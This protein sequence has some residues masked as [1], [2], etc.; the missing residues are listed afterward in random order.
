M[1]T[2]ITSIS[3]FVLFNCFSQNQIIK[4]LDNKTFLD[5]SISQKTYSISNLLIDLKETPEYDVALNNGIKFKVFFDSQDRATKIYTDKCKSDAITLK[6]TNIRVKSRFSLGLENSKYIYNYA[7][8]NVVGFKEDYIKNIEDSKE[9]F[10]IV[11]S[12]KVDCIDVI[13]N[14]ESRYHGFFNDRNNQQ[15]ILSFN[16]ITNPVKEIQDGFYNKFSTLTF[17]PNEDFMV[18]IDVPF[19]WELRNKED[20]IHKSTKAVFLPYRGFL[21]S[22]IIINIS[23]KKIIATKEE[24]DEEQISNNDIIEMIYNDDEMLSVLFNKYN[25]YDINVTLMNNGNRKF[26]YYTHKTDMNKAL[27]SVLDN[28]TLKSFG[29]VGFDYGKLI[30]VNTGATVDYYGFGAYNYYSKLFYKMLST[31][32]IKEIEKDIIYIEDRGNSKYINVEIGAEKYDFMLD[33]GASYVTINKKIFNELLINGIINKD[34]FIEKTTAEIADGSIVNVERWF[35]PKMKIGNKTITDVE[36]LV[37]DSMESS[38]LFGL[39]GIKKLDVVKFD[40]KNNEI[41]VNLN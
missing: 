28:H 31:V 16:Y 37:L 4:R 18:T 24:M 12:S 1:K 40:L 19:S 35:I 25:P 11:G 5:N 8:D 20:L 7:V 22:N 14:F 3:F 9:L 30:F 2:I 13:Y 34:D 17:A 41:R 32:R 33:T 38:L 36:V 10:E 26:I 39:N 6:F 27:N 21:S 23:N 29:I 15:N